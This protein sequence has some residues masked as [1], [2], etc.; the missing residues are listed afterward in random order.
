MKPTPLAFA[1]LLVS[2][3]ASADFPPLSPNAAV[4][5]YHAGFD[6]YFVTSLP[7]EIAALD[8]GQL[9]GW[10]RT[11]RGF[12]VFSVAP[13]TPFPVG[14]VC[15]FYIPPQH[16]DSHFFSASADEC[17]AVRAR[18]GTDPNYS[19][20]VEESSHVFYVAL[21]D[22]ATG[23]CPAG[24]G[25]VYRLWNQRAD[26]NH[27]Y[28]TDAGI[29]S[30]M[31]GKG[32]AA[33][34]YGPDAVAMCTQRPLLVDA[35][36]VTSGLSPLPPGCDGVPSNQTVYV[37]AE[38]EPMIAVNPA[39]TNNVIAAW[40][41]DRWSGGGSRGAVTAY[42]MDGGGT[43]TKSFAPMS[44]C[45]GGAGAT[46]YER[47]SDPWVTF[48]PDGT[49]Y[50]VSLSFNNFVNGN[51]AILVSRSTDGGRTWSAA[52]ALRQ[53]G[54]TN[55]NDKESATADR[56]DARYVYATWDRLAG[57][58]APTWFTRT[59]DGG[60]TWEAARA[61]YDPGPNRQTLNNQVA[62]LPNGTLALFFSELPTV[63]NGQPALLR[64]MRSTDKGATWS[65]PITVSDM[66]TVGTTDPD[67]G[68]DI[69]DAEAIAAVSAG[70]NGVLAAVWQDSRFAGGAYDS[71]AFSKSTDGGITWSAPVRINGDPAVFALL[72][73]VAIAGDGTIGVTY[74][75][76]RDN[77]PDPS[78]LLT[79]VW[80]A[81]SGDGVTWSER[82]IDGPFDYAKAP[83]VGGRYFLGDYSGMTSSATSF[84]TAFGRANDDPGNRSDIVVS[85]ARPTAETT[86]VAIG[87]DPGIAPSPRTTARMRRAIENALRARQRPTPE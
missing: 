70:A 75:D 39:N 28:S 76:F 34:G 21:P 37:N 55:Q 83:L 49:A 87:A 33:E 60:A 8:T 29:K 14:A 23:A 64:L 2:L 79:D 10:S 52:T 18:I 45:T 68:V 66:Q 32:Y 12:A 69:R 47:A 63:D 46:A 56:T 35:L 13:P 27:R 72:P 19:G 1:A 30:F 20:Y 58:N 77:T 59:V 78:T 16:G 7:A 11:G 24:Y 4:E 82:R 6:H 50:Q 5:Y 73:N 74:Y 65:A 62:V 22:F 80:L 43:W 85:L 84:L 53:D 38:V 15:R 61:I 51:N 57:N 25:P 71:V 9:T 26:S 44:R 86:A 36:V 31:I 48:A 41:Q 17:A 40:Q 81:T 3:P 67:T 42:S 54:G